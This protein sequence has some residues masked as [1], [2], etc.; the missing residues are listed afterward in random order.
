MRK[1]L[2]FLL[3]TSLIFSF[4]ACGAN[5]T[6]PVVIPEPTDMVFA[7]FEW[8]GTD[9]A[10]LMPVP[11]SNVGNIGWSQDYGFVIYVAETSTD[12][13]AA[14]VAECK[15]LG[16]TENINSG[17]TWYYADNA[18]GYHVSMK[19]QGEDVMFVRI[20]APPEETPE[21]V[22]EETETPIEEP[23]LTVTPEPIDISEPTETPEPMPTAIPEPEPIETPESK[24]EYDDLRYE[25]QARR[26]FENYGERVYQYGIEYH[27]YSGRISEYEG[28]GVWHLKVNVTITNAFGATTE[29][30]AE[31]RIDFVKEAVTEFE[32]L[33]DWDQ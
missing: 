33:D 4:A 22:L 11:K 30:V 6:A 10:K 29:A 5:T 16:F 20:D 3:A 25:T 17:E 15:A 1:L 32:I 21:P 23:E 2:P 27:W 12:D 14:Y 13:Y 26:A 19:Y 24:D 9:I 31:G 18:D 7:E 28:D 8:P